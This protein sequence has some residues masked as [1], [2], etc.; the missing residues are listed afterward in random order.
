[1]I[2]PKIEV[3]AGGKAFYLSLPIKTS[4]ELLGTHLA[5]NEALLCT[6]RKEPFVPARHRSVPIQ[7][8]S[9]TE[10]VS[11]RQAAAWTASNLRYTPFNEANPCLAYSQCK[12]SAYG[13]TWRDSDTTVGSLWIRSHPSTLMWYHHVWQNVMN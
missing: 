10:M 2:N 1:M 9:L 5:T 11:M 4:R 6:Y 7:Y 8:R 12:M 13:K 3:S